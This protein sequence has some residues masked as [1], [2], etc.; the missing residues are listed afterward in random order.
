MVKNFDING[1]TI[2]F[3]GIGGTGVSALASIAIDRGCK[4][5]GSDASKSKYTDELEKKGCKIYFKHSGENISNNINLLVYSGAIKKNNPEL[6]E[7]SRKGIK[8]MSRSQFLGL[9]T[10][11]F[12]NLI[13]VSGSHGKTTTTSMLTSIMINAKKSPT[14]IIGAYFDEIKGNSIS[15][16]SDIAIC[17]SCEFLD[18]FLD[19]N[20]KIGVI[21]NVD[22]DHL[23]YFKNIENEKESFLKFAQKCKVVVINRDNQNAYEISK[24]LKNQKII[25]YGLNQESEFSASDISINSGYPKFIVNKN[26]KNI[27]EL[28]LKVP[29]KHNILNSLASIAVCSLFDVDYNVL[30]ESLENFSGAERRF[31]FLGKLKGI[32]IFD[33]YAHHPSEI[34]AILESAKNMNFNK[35]WAIFQ[36]H[37]F[38]RT[39][40]LMDD[41]AK[42]LSLADNLII[43]DIL[44][45]REV[46]T[47]G[48]T[49][50]DL[51]K[52][53]PGSK[54]IKNFEDIADYLISNAK[55]G[56]MIITIGAGNIYKCAEMI[57][58]R[59]K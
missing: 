57:Y 32:S 37:T 58:S 26:G 40:L 3:V 25:Y 55:S 12:E 6:I 8:C 20:P 24:K 14:A 35:I 42:S 31:R 22:N 47:Y 46:N 43:T 54:V 19:L 48:V 7:A 4:V 49:S 2:H 33:D 50:E 45:V 13:A 30:K 9:I 5:Q 21:L 52:K 59:L 16:N 39:Y 17:E 34:K 18:S 10:S 44:P 23:D 36:P 11:D 1:K 56:D 38:S 15:G 41:F 29:G 53:I 28:K 51:S 27:L